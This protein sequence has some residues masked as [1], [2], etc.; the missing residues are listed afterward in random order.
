MSADALHCKTKPGLLL[1]HFF[2]DEQKRFEKRLH[3]PA[4]ITSSMLF[5]VSTEFDDENSVKL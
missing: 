2:F 4:E 5:S 1:Q 3:K